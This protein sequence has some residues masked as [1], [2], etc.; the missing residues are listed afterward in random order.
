MKINK[1]KIIGITGGIGS[2]KTTAAKYFEALGFP[3]YN[4]DQRARMIQNNNP[5]V[6][7]AIKNIFGDESYTSE[8]MNRSY[9]ASKTFKDKELLQQL[10]AIVHPAVFKDF[11]DWIEQQNTDFVIKEA[12]IL[13]E[14]GSYKDCDLIISVIAD[15][16]IRITRTIERDGLTREQVEARMK[17]Q[18]SDEERKE[19]SDYIIDNSQDLM[20]LQQQVKNLAAIIKKQH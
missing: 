8:G 16:E 9:I 5:E 14:S 3:L 12:A 18:L 2:G 10:N 1:P 13:I 19:Y 20:H 17:N 15:Q 7:Q 4:S 11:K 6:I